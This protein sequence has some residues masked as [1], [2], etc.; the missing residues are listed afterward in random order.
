MATEKKLPAYRGWYTP[1]PDTTHFKN[2]K[3]NPHTGVVTYPPS[4]TKMEFQDQC[5]INNILKQYKVSGIVTHINARAS[6]GAYLDLPREVDFQTSLNI[7]K[8]GEQAFATLPSKI[9]DRFGNSPEKF[10]AFC[11]DPENKD[12]MIKL[13]LANAPLEVGAPS[14][15]SSSPLAASGSSAPAG[16]GDGGS[17]KPP[18]GGLKA[19]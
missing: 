4:R 9:R 8:R 19:P 16:A 2:E 18:E 17:P 1:R 6:Q 3:V 11:A 5:D 10:L 14:S 13:G 7:V 12:E 15:S